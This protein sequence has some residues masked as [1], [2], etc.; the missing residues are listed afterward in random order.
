MGT[1]RCQLYVLLACVGERERGGNNLGIH[2]QGEGEMEERD[3]VWV[4]E[5]ERELGL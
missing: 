3:C 4:K 1:R 2:H 5:R